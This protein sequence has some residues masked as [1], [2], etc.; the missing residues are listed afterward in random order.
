M[1]IPVRIH[2]CMYV[3]FVHVILFLLRSKRICSCLLQIVAAGAGAGQHSSR[4]PARPKTPVFR[5]AQKHVRAKLE[6]KWLSLFLQSPEYI[7]RNGV[8]LSEKESKTQSDTESGRVTT[9]SGSVCA[10]TCFNER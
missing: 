4:L 6:R 8:L 3:Y 5:E 2:A 9:V 7:A 1:Y 10:R